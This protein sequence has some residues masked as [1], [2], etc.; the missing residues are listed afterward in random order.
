MTSVG[1]LLQ[2]KNA[3]LMFA[4]LAASAFLT[5][6]SSILPT[7]IMPTPTHTRVHILIPLGAHSFHI[8]KHGGAPSGLKLIAHYRSS[9]GDPP[10]SP[11]GD[12]TGVGE[13]L[14]PKLKRPI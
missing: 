14:C 6:I 4:V 7:S 1:L 2:G 12:W 5:S 3:T 10:Y 8:T 11:S 13:N 9:S